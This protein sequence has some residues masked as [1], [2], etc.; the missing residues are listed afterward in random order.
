MLSLV[1]VG[2]VLATCVVAGQWFRAASQRRVHGAVAAA[3]ARRWYER[4]GAEV[5]TLNDDGSALV[6]QALSDASERYASAGAALGTASSEQQFRLARRTALE[7]LYFARTAR[8]ALGLDAGP[9][10][11]ALEDDAQTP[12]N[13]SNGAPV[14]VPAASGFGGHVAPGSLKASVAGL[15]LG[16]LACDLLGGR[17][18]G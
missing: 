6:R 10:L 8:A 16:L 18:S 14:P 17:S 12:A 5:S 15:G 9:Q 2:F 7:G 11:P 13:R 4:L 1:L 3:D